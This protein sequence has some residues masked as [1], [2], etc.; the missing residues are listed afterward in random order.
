MSSDSEK[1]I[2]TEKSSL[3][4]AILFFLSLFLGIFG[5]DRFYARK[6][7]SG[8]LKL[9]TLF[10]SVALWG[11]GILIWWI[12]DLFIIA[13][14]KFTDGFGKKV[15]NASWQKGLSLTFTIPLAIFS[16][17]A[18]FSSPDAK[19]PE[20]LQNIPEQ[21]QNVPKQA[22]KEQKYGDREQKYRE[23]YGEEDN[24]LNVYSLVRIYKENPLQA[25]EICQRNG[26][27]IIKGY[28]ANMGSNSLG[29]YIDL[30]NTHPR[31]ETITWL[32]KIIGGK[33][34]GYVN[35]VDESNEK[36]GSDLGSDTRIFLEYSDWNSEAISKIK[37]NDLIR[38]YGL[39]EGQAEAFGAKS[40]IIIG[41]ARIL[42]INDDFL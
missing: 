16:A 38:F 39:C 12:I 7:I 36:F 6:K 35:T 22:Q 25:N 3:S 5:V 9:I 10:V 41:N 23:L 14:G 19:T 30:R 18:F 28:I 31:A 8:I 1:V 42:K 26:H 17:I 27:I 15:Q 2:E 34:Y 32:L 11:G 33:N 4:W 24:V 21:T 40:K 20:Q 29:N 13:N 37:R